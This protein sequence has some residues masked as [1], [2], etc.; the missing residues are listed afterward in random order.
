MDVVEKEGQVAR[1]KGRSN[2]REIQVENELGGKSKRKG[3]ERR[4]RERRKP[5]E[6]RVGMKEEGTQNKTREGEKE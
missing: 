4:D 5:K 1:N 2:K 3:V 6:V